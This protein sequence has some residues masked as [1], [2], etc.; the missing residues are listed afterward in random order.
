MTSGAANTFDITTIRKITYDLTQ[1][2][3]MAVVLTTSA[4]Q[5][6]D[7]AAIRSVI[8]S[9]IATQAEQAQVKRIKT[10]LVSFVLQRGFMPLVSFTVEKPEIVRIKIY[11]ILGKLVRSVADQQFDAGDNTVFWDGLDEQGRKPSTG[12]YIM[13]IDRASCTSAFKFKSLIN[14]SPGSNRPKKNE[15]DKRLVWQ[16]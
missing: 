15:T 11:T 4:T 2:P 14:V 7:I 10:D 6:L 9:G 5:S 8:F 12:N 3:K 1:A 13:K 16:L